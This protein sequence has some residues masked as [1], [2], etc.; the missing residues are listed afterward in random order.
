[1][2]YVDTWDPFQTMLHLLG[3]NVHCSQEQDGG[4]NYSCSLPYC[5]M[6]FLSQ[7]LLHLVQDCL[8]GDSL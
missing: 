5:Q 7:K 6:L 3:T 2:T 8:V 4:P 1:M